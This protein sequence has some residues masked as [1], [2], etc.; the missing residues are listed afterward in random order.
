MQKLLRGERP[1]QVYVIKLNL[2][3]S[4]K[5]A[6]YDASPSPLRAGQGQLHAFT[7]PIRRYP[8]LL[9]HAS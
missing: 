1:S 4:L 7:S 2:L 9:V 8:D 5:R 3:K 6:M